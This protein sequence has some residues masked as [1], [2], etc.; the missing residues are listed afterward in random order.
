MNVYGIEIFLYTWNPKEA[1]MIIDVQEWLSNP[2]IPTLVITAVF[3]YIG[4]K[5][6]LEREKGGNS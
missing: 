3:V 1:C 6:G 4:L 5:Y 2:I